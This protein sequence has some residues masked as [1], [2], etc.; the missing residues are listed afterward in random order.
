MTNS[1]KT[2]SSRQCSGRMGPKR[3]E[4]VSKTAGEG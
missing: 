1:S 4:I 3:A 2:L